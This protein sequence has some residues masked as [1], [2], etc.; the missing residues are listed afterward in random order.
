LA[1]PANDIPDDRLAITCLHCGKSQ[2]IPKR[3]M[4]IT[5]KHCNKSLRLE[6]IR[7]KEYEARRVI[8]TCGVVTIE[9]KANVVV[10]TKIHCGG[11]IIRGRVKGEII[12]HG[13]VLVGPDAE[14]KGDVTAPSMAVGAGAVL[15]GNYR[16][17][18]NAPL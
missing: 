3:A 9:K 2:E 12:S 17:G 5:C 11:L 10:S 6:D 8:E 18:K 1:A 15:E 7:Y 13:P 4:S 16:V 14:V